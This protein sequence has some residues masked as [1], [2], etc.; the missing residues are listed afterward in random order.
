MTPPTTTPTDE[1]LT[2]ALLV[3]T[4]GTLRR[5]AAICLRL[6][7]NNTAAVAVNEPAASIGHSK[8]PR[9]T[10]ADA[11]TQ[12]DLYVGEPAKKKAR[13]IRTLPHVVCPACE[14]KLSP[15]KLSEHMNMHIMYT[16]RPHHCKQCD[17]RYAYKFSLQCHQREVH[18]ELT[19]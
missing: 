4:P 6:L 17:A 12:T 13:R 9:Q 1:Q 11:C 10:T 3:F 18:P 2:N 14:K 8:A 16:R 15:R 19:F 7:G 5:I